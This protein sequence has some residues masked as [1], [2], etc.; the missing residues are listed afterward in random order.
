MNIIE[1]LERREVCGE[2]ILVPTGEK[3]V[4]FSK[5][6]SLNDTSLFLWK[7]MEKGEFTPAELVKALLDEYEIDEATASKDVDS[8]IDQLLKEGLIVR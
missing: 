4:D 8:F 3:S 7:K 2:S 5:L 6:V 1:G